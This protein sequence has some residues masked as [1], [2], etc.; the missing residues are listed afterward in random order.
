ML[1]KY[2]Q[3]SLHKFW[4]RGRVVEVTKSTIKVY[5]IEDKDTTITFNKL[6]ANYAKKGTMTQ[7][8]E[9]RTKLKQGIYY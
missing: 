7:E 3:N 6:S 9:W 2:Y 1:E 5:V 4:T 8:W